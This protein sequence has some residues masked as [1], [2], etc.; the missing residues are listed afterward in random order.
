MR[1]YKS[2]IFRLPEKLAIV[3]YVQLESKRRRANINIFTKM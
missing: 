1:L 2:A 3:T